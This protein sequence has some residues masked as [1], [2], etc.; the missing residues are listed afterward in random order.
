MCDG[1]SQSVTGIY[2]SVTGIYFYFDMIGLYSLSHEWICLVVSTL[3]LVLYIVT[4]Y[5]VNTPFEHI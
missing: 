5:I 1:Y 2:L 3:L 4:L